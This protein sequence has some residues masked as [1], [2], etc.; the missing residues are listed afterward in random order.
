MIPE[1]FGDCGDT[2]VNEVIA[3]QNIG[4]TVREVNGRIPII[5]AIQI[6]LADDDVADAIR[7]RI[8]RV[9]GSVN[10][11]TLMKMSEV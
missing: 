8:D 10:I 1:K 5:I 4:S 2:P 3:D 6:V 7:H 11:T 9:G